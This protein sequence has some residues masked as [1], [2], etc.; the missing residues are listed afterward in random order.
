MAPPGPSQYAVAP[1]TYRLHDVLM[2][3]PGNI[4]KLKA[5]SNRL[6]QFAR[7]VLDDTLLN[8]YFELRSVLEQLEADGSRL[9]ELVDVLAYAV[10][11]LEG[12]LRRRDVP[13]KAPYGSKM[14]VQART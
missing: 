10:K 7:D 6:A 3:D 2:E 4:A 8:S 9:R 12:E 11:V 1:P 14:L 13:L 5:C